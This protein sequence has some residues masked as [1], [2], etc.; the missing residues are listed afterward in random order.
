MPAYYYVEPGAT[1]TT[2]ATGNTEN[3]SLFIAPGSAAQLILTFLKLSGKAAAATSLSGIVCRIK[4]WTTTASSAGTAI[5]PAP[6]ITAFAAAK[7]SAGYSTSA[8]TSGTGGPLLKGMVACGVSGTDIYQAQTSQFDDAPQAQP[9][10]TQ[11]I[12]A[13]VSSGTASLPYELQGKIAE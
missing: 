7:S 13:F 5:T 4:Q 8:V 11:S 2:N 10:A 1:Q 12:D 6:A 9:G 3:D